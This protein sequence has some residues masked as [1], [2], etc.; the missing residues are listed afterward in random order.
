VVVWDNN[1]KGQA[2]INRDKKI[3]A[4]VED[5]YGLGLA[6]IT[7]KRRTPNFQ[8]VSSVIFISSKQ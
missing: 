4:A 3:M 6:I 2:L 5:W 7:K 1:T 8:Q